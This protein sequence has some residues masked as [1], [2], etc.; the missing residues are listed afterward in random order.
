MN[1]FFVD[2]QSKTCSNLLWIVKENSIELLTNQ[3]S[4]FDFSFSNEYAKKGHCR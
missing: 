2:I 3:T 1:Y 4:M